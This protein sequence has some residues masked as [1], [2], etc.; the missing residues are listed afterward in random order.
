MTVWIVLGVVEGLNPWKDEDHARTQDDPDGEVAQGGRD[1]EIKGRVAGAQLVAVLARDDVSDPVEAVLD[2]PMASG[3]GG[4]G[5]GRSVGHG[6]GA[7][8]SGPPR[9]ASRP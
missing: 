6:E 4:D 5:L 7:D 8:P 9:R 2:G 1:Q 3:P